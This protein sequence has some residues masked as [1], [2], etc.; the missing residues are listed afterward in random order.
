M[1]DELEKR[2][3]ARDL[4]RLAYI[5]DASI[6]IPGTQFKFGLDSLV[7]LIPGIGDAAGV[8][9]SLY[10]LLRARQ[11]GVPGRTLVKML[12]NIAADG[13]LGTVPVAGDIFDAAFR[14]N[15]RNV[16]LALEAMPE[17]QEALPD[18]DAESADPSPPEP[19]A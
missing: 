2:A 10:I 5:M 18:P 12:G 1:S 11:L 7:G 15:Q 16:K 19:P 13:L 6:G 4:E 17:L 14:A 9:I 8:C 3:T